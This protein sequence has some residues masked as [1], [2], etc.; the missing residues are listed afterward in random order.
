[1]EGCIIMEA[2]G[3]GL[4]AIGS[5]VGAWATAFGFVYVIGILTKT[6]LIYTGKGEKADFNNWF[7]FWGNK[8][9]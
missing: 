8:G 6:F 4:Q 9:L 2:I 7:K 1:M 5:A 3:I